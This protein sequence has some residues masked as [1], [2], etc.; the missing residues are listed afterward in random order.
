MKKI[1]AILAACT[2]VS[3]AM[4][5]TASAMTL[6]EFNSYYKEVI[7]KS[8]NGVEFSAT[9]DVNNDG[10]TDAADCSE[11]LSFYT[12]SVNGKVISEEEFKAFAENGDMNGDGIVDALDASF[13]L[14]VYAESYNMAHLEARAEMDQLLG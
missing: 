4:P 9:G 11:I 10:L 13:A 6:D 14:T 8:F 12:D 3:A 1:T 2:L 7:D 5:V